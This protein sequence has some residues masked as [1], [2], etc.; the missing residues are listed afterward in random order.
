MTLRR[1]IWVLGVYV[2]VLVACSVLLFCV[3]RLDRSGAARGPTLVNIWEK[4][5]RTARR[6]VPNEAAAAQA[7]RDEEAAPGATRIVEQ[8]VDSAPILPLGRLV[9]AASVAPVRDGV[10][11]TYHGNTAYLTPDDLLKL[12]AYEG[13]VSLGPLVLV[14]GIDPDKVLG[15]LATDLHTTPGELFRNGSFRR[16]SVARDERYPKRNSNEPISVDALKSAVRSAARYLVQNQHPDGSFRYEVNAVTGGDE[17]GY[18][19]PRHAGATY[20]LARTANQFHDARLFRA[21]E[22]AGTFMKDHATLSCGAHSCV[23][24]GDT[25][26]VGASALATLAYVELL[27]GGS[28]GISRCGPRSGRVFA[29]SAAQRRRFSAHLFSRGA[30]PR[31]HSTRVLHGR[32]GVCAVARAACER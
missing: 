17:P 24:E 6:V 4:G 31:R 15:A 30:A 20:F 27:N 26:D 19:Y 5:A 18:N 32:S 14:L 16:F 29:R 7:L 10:S 23:G 22:L 1:L 9:F 3:V 21:A 2:G 11:A 28:G 25:V 13:N 8:I 12:E